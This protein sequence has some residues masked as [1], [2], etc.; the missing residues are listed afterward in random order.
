MIVQIVAI[1]L[2]A[3]I[4]AG[5]FLVYDGIDRTQYV[6]YSE[7]SNIE[8]KVQYTDNEFFDSEWIDKDYAYISSLISKITA[9][10]AY[11]I[12]V[13][14]ENMDIK[15]TYWVDA[16][17]TVTNKNDG[18]HYY[19]FEENILPMRSAL[20]K[21][22]NQVEI[23]ESVDV[24]YTVYDQ[25]ARSFIKAYD[26]KN[27]TSL[28]TVTLYVE[29]E[30]SNEQFTNEC[31][32]N[33]SSSLNIPLAEDTFS[34]YSTQSSPE[35]ENKSFEYQSGIIQNA[36]LVALVTLTIVAAAVAVLLVIGLIVFLK[37][38]KNE[39]ITYAARIRKILSAYGSFIQRID[40]DFDAEGYQIVLIKTFT[41]ML[42]IRDTIQ[43]PV[44]MFENRD[45]TM[46]RFFIPTNTKILYVFEIKVDNYDE[47]YGKIEEVAEEEEIVEEPIVEEPIV[48]E[49][50]VEEPAIEEVTEEPIILEEVN[51]EELAEVMA[52]P[53][54]D[55]AE[56]EYIPDDDDQFE[57]APEEPGIEVVGVVWPEKAHKNKVYRYDPNGEILSAGD[58]VVV[59]T[60][61]RSKGREVI[62]KVAVAHGNHRVDPEH[63]K[64]PLKKIIA[65]LKHSVTHS[66]TP[67]AN[68]QAKLEAE[69]TENNE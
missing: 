32:S 67:Q 65:V 3:V 35:G 37:L 59:P 49:P 21:N 39:D 68:E 47:I 52:Q 20:F 38:T 40:G 56:I 30:C 16:K 27:A 8:Y 11:N 31:T 36:F 61:D 64:F 28:L 63:I 55:L 17:L 19:T 43:S 22:K 54:I 45:E 12:D 24:N 2:F 58:I 66:L 51:E 42:G 69:N 15:Y 50:V 23:T 53:D 46:T 1:A 29:A 60:M 13:E 9:D 7:N 44:L 6:E 10:F 26:L 62:R 57:V 41:E 5:S 18:N 48:E 14:S 25:R 34:V 33:Y 4:S